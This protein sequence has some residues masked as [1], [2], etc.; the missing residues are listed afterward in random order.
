MQPS[1]VTEDDRATG[2]ICTSIC[3]PGWDRLRIAHLST[4]DR[5]DLFEFAGSHAAYDNF[6]F[7]RH[8]M[9]HFVIKDPDLEGLLARIIAARGKQRMPL[10]EYFP[11]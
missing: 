8:G 4:G 2:V 3:G 11:G 6:D 9:F 5:I 1:T 10:R 7:R